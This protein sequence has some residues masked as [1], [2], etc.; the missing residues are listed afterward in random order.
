MIHDRAGDYTKNT[1][2]YRVLAAMQPPKE[3][4]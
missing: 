2:T 1:S 4:V 3:K